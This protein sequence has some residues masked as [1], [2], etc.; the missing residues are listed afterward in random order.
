MFVQ[1]ICHIDAQETQCQEKLERQK[2]AFLDFLISNISMDDKPYIAKKLKLLD[3]K[4]AI[5][6]KLLVPTETA[7][8]YTK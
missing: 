3:T 1:S 7:K 6:K 4:L 2:D 5:L 8:K